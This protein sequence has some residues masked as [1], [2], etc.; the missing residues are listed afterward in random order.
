MSESN[1]TENQETIGKA[2][3]SWVGKVIDEKYKILEQ[4]GRGGTGVVYKAEHI[5]INR[6]VA[7]KVLHP[8]LVENEDSLKRFQHEAK[9]A[10]RLNHPSAVLLYDFGI[11]QNYPYLVMQYVEGKTLKQLIRD[12]GSLSLHEVYE[13]FQQVTS[14]LSEAHR[15]GIIH[16]DLKPEN[17]MITNTDDGNRRVLVLDFGIAKLLHQAGEK[18]ATLV[19]Q[20]G[21]FYGTPQYASPEQVLSK[22]LDARSDIYSLGIILYEALSGDLP[23]DAPS[24]ME[25][26]FKQLNELPIAL[27]EKKPPLPLGRA[28]DAL[29]MK[30]LEKDPGKRYQSV[31]E[32][33]DDLQ[34]VSANLGKEQLTKGKSL[35]VYAGILGIICVG[36]I[37]AIF[38][39]NQ[40]GERGAGVSEFVSEVNSDHSESENSEIIEKKQALE[41]V[42][43]T[44]EEKTSLPASENNLVEEEKAKTTESV[45]EEVTAPAVASTGVS[46]PSP[47]QAPLS[48]A[49]LTVRSDP[50]GA[51]VFFNDVRQGVTPLTLPS[52]TVGELQLSLKLSGFDEHRQNLVTEAGK[53]NAIDVTLKKSAD[54]H[55]AAADA[56]RLFQSGEKLFNQKQYAG[57]IQ[58][59]EQ[60]IALRP[61]HIKARLVLGLCYLRVG[62][63]EESLKQFL[64][65][66]K[67][68]SN[69]APVHFNLAC[70]YSLQ[71]DTQKAL[72]FLE[73]SIR[74]NPRIRAW[75][76][77]EPDLDAI[78]QTARFQKLV[79]IHY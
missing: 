69:Y 3:A 12:K 67:L 25:I 79:S 37:G 71:G 56:D 1:T 40:F 39:E 14:A 66:G 47:Q 53:E 9:V 27:R 28:V 22:E 73:R 46:E 24:L 70:Y 61:G 55:L 51:E 59:L 19:T 60:A 17:I 63:K 8:H 76:V 64:A 68:D 41:T 45:Q 38:Y 35:K 31:K 65:A 75:A 29:V 21:L 43:Q 33:L 7:I 54:P 74:L 10:S 57:A 44:I 16:R 52:V 32:L 48:N 23:F 5:L 18:A 2:A 26:L 49:S 4:L 78:R 36:V 6:T 13:I 42:S 34:V 58:D 77:Q 20:E 72:D 11:L 50:L 30:C 15:L 62:R